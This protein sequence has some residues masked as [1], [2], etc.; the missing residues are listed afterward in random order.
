MSASAGPAAS[1]AA[2]PAAT[3]PRLL[4]LLRQQ[5]RVLHISLFG[6]QAV[7]QVAD[8]LAQVVEQARAQGGWGVGQ[9]RAVGHGFAFKG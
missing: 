1:P 9:V 7:V 3:T 4:D 6:A 2:S 8:L 5:A